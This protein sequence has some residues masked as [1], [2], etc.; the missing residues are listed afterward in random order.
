M[1]LDCHVIE[2]SSHEYSSPLP[3]PKKK[4][5]KNQKLE[6]KNCFSIFQLKFIISLLETYSK[7]YTFKIS[8]VTESIFSSILILSLKLLV[9][10]P[11][12]TGDLA[13]STKA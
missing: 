7:D 2:F 8:G 1:I 13:A 9:S 3:P 4:P 10:I 11:L 6:F 5:K 12:N